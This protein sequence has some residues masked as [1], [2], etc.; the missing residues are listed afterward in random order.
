MNVRCGRGMLI[1]KCYVGGVET[2]LEDKYGRELRLHILRVVRCGRGRRIATLCWC[3]K[4]VGGG[5]Y[6]GEGD[7][8]ESEACKICRKGNG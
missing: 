8:R 6:A 5:G 2:T 4:E 3:G 1:K 7:A